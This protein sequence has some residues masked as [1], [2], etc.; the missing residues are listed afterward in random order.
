MRAMSPMRK[1]GAGSNRS[2]ERIHVNLQGGSGLFAAA[3]GVACRNVAS[4]SLCTHDGP[5]GGSAG[6]RRWQFVAGASTTTREQPRCHGLE[7]HAISAL[8]CNAS[9]LLKTCCAEARSH[10]RRDYI[11]TGLNIPKLITF[12]KLSSQSL[13]ERRRCCSISE[14]YCPNKRSRRGFHNSH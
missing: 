4:T 12:S 8:G 13:A 11:Y 7:E 14:S 2:S 9:N 1:P 3:Q 6:K 10:T 5:A